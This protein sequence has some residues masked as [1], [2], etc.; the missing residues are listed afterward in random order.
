[1][2]NAEFV[3]VQGRQSARRVDG[4][5]IRELREDAGVTLSRFARSINTN[6]TH[7]SRIE[8]GLG[9]PG[10]EL[11]VAIAAKL[12]VGLDEILLTA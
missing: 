11:R 7:L 6:P 4:P 2:T 3:A 12:G 1:M 5:R 10:V 8:R 9:Q